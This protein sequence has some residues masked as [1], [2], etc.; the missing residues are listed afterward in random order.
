MGLCSLAVGNFRN[1]QAVEVS[2]AATLNI[3]YGENAAGKTSLLEAIHFLARVRSFRP[4]RVEQLIRDG[5]DSLWVRGQVLAGERRVTAAVQRA[6]GAT[7]V[8]IDGQDARSL[9]SLARYFP[10][11]VIHSESQRLLLDGPRVRRSFLNW[12]LFHVEP[13][14]Y[15]TW[16]RYDRAVRQR[17]A[18]LK[19]GDRRLLRAWEPEL[20]QAGEGLDAMRTELVRLLDRQLQP[21]LREWLPEQVISLSYRRGWMQELSL[22]Q[23]LERHRERELDTG[24]CMYGPHRSDLLVRAGGVEA[25][26]RLSRGQQKLVV[27]G[28]L[29]AQARVAAEAA[30]YRPLL[31]IDDLAAELDAQRREAVLAVLGRSPVQ[32]FITCVEPESL[33]V[34]VEAVKWFHVEHGRYREVV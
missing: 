13:N 6:E 32:S 30:E 10:L 21:L 7:R 20:C 5:A 4:T 15:A 17:N 1:L 12:T 25:Q 2:P 3:V 24:Y 8:R 26:Y 28:L 14:Y 22:A 29:I 16:R 27:I 31:L 9:S 18:A 33:P 23:A 11:Q 19:V 34:A